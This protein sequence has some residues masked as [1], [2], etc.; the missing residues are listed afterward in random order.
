MQ[1]IVD[2]RWFHWKWLNKQLRESDTCT[3]FHL[4]ESDTEFNMPGHYSMARRMVGRWLDAHVQ[5]TVSSWETDTSN[6]KAALDC[7]LLSD[8]LQQLLLAPVGNPTVSECDDGLIRE[9]GTEDESTDESHV[10]EPMHNKQIYLLFA[11]S[12]KP[13]DT[14][15]DQDLEEEVLF[16]RGFYGKGNEDD[17][18]AVEAEGAKLQAEIHAALVAADMQLFTA[19]VK[20]IDQGS[21]TID[22][23]A[24]TIKCSTSADT[25]S[26]DKLTQ[27]AILSLLNQWMPMYDSRF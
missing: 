20:V 11:A 22:T 2:A 4:M 13:I 10:P 5:W 12:L 15:S 26:K 24:R 8:N 19:T 9:T 16:L 18:T 23:A 27:R 21:L 17:L 25:E 3:L 1:D 6:G 7:L 14:A